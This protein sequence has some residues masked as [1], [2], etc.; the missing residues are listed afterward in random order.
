MDNIQVTE[1]LEKMKISNVDDGRKVFDFL[2][3]L[4]AY[5]PIGSTISTN[6]IDLHKIESDFIRLDS[7]VD[8]LELTDF[9]EKTKIIKIV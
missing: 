5:M 1:L 4:L 3:N 6:L 2:I 7:K 9:V 8:E